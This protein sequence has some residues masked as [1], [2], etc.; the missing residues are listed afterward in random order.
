MATSTNVIQ[1]TITATDAVGN[2]SINRGFG[3]PSFAGT[4]GDMTIN[5]QLNNASNNI[6]L[7]ISGTIT[8]VQNIYVKNNAAP[9]GGTVSVNVSINGAGPVTVAILQPGGVFVQWNVTSP[10]VAASQI[11]VLALIASVANIPVEYFIGA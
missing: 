6:P 7:P 8:G 9:G 3:N 2:T 10:P 11:T 5:Q 1:A 4:V